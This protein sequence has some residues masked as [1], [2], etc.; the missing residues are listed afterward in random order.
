MTCINGGNNQ[1]LCSDDECKIC[2]AKTVLLYKNIL[3]WDYN[4]NNNENPRK[5][6]CSSIQQYW[7]I[8]SKCNHNTYIKP[9]SIKKKKECSYCS[10]MKLCGIK[11]CTICFN[12]S[13]AS[14]IMAKDWDYKKNNIPPY[15]VHKNTKI[16]YWF[17]CNRC[18]HNFKM[19]I[20]RITLGSKCRFC[21]GCDLCD[22]DKCK[23]CFD[24][25]FA[26]EKESLKW[27]YKQ[28]NEITPRMIFK[29]CNKKFWFKCNICL[30]NY[31][32]I[33]NDIMTKGVNC[34][35]CANKELCKNELCKICK[36][37]SFA[38]HYKSA[39]WDVN[40][41]DGLLP[42]DFTKFSS[43]IAWFKCEDCNTSFKHAISCITCAGYW[44]PLCNL[45]TEKKLFM[46]L[47]EIFPSINRDLKFDWCKNEKTYKYL[48]F[49]FCIEEL[50][51]I[52]ELD[53]EQ[54]FKQVANWTS[55]E[56]TQERDI[57]KMKRAI[58]N[59][60]SVIRLLQEDVYKDKNNWK[61]NLLAA[62]KKYDEPTCIFLSNDEDKY[63]NH[64][65]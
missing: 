11:S 25:S 29:N 50:K 34:R 1:K 48:P 37:K 38:S 7:F 52:I 27:D 65:I 10:G 44:C 9:S 36:D 64:Q 6:F 46:F 59:G 21:M 15:Q 57:Y 14:L 30:H 53:G 19:C 17:N 56:A 18:N 47:I 54:H 63:N 40:K 23:F 2:E 13:F 24:K 51:L 39:Y 49:D 58:E 33:P 12:N 35:F 3:Q 61:E 55:P 62:I 5:I 4:K 28:N 8:C 42:R 22:N 31:N 26:S 43:K 16:Y 20:S 41:N 60:Y 45:K 32:T